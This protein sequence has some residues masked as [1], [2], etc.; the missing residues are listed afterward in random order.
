MTFP[1]KKTADQELII[2]IRE[3]GNRRRFFENSLYNKYTYFIKDAVFKHKIN[4][5]DASMAYSDTILTVIEHIALGRFEGRSELK[6]YIYQIFYNKCVDVIRKNTTNK[7]SG[8]SLDDLVEPVP[9]SQRSALADLIRQQ[10][11]ER[12]RRLLGNLGE[13]C[14]ELLK[15]W[16]EGFTDEESAQE[17]GY[18]S[19]GVAQTTR[20]RCLEKLREM[21]K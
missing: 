8:I 14:Q 2:G 9:D 16:S 6:T 20:L 4:E 7:M 15:R 5:E 19:A 12:L 21:Y 18:N 11:H 1:F 13:R 17:F 3:G 10:D